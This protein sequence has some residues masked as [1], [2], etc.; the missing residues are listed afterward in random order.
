MRGQVTLRSVL[1]AASPA[2]IIRGEWQTWRMSRVQG[3]AGYFEVQ[4]TLWGGLQFGY[5]ADAMWLWCG[6]GLPGD[7]NTGLP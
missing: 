1:L 2:E 6:V 3:E 4:F 5:G 7:P